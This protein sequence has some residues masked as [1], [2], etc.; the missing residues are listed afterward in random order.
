MKHGLTAID[1]DDDAQMEWA[2]HHGG[3]VR[4]HKGPMHGKLHLTVK[5]A[6]GQWFLTLDH[7]NPERKTEGVGCEE[8]GAAQS[9]QGRTWQVPKTVEHEPRSEGD[10]TARDQR[11]VLSA[12][13]VTWFGARI[14]RLDIAVPS[15]DACQYRCSDAL[16][17]VPLESTHTGGRGRAVDGAQRDVHAAPHLIDIE[18]SADRDQR[19]GMCIG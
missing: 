11:L 5:P 12:V 16:P 14:Y 2:S 13:F 19:V 18:S 1:L 17:T 15:P 7:A 9:S 10:G 6:E 4:M 3:R 8:V